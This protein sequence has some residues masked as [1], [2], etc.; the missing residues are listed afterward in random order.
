MIGNRFTNYIPPEYTDG[1]FEQL[2]KIFMQLVTITSGDVAEA[3]NWMNEVDRQYKLTD[4]DYG[5]GDFIEEL[6][7]RGYIKENQEQNVFVLTAKSELSIRRQSLEEIFGKLKKSAK[8][9][10]TTPFSGHGDELTS[11]RREYNFG[12]TL[13]QIDMTDSIKNAQINHGLDDFKLTEKDLEIEEKDF[14]ALTSTVLMIDVSHSMVL[15]G[16]DRITPAKKVAM[17]LAELITTKYPKDTLDIIA[18]GND[19]FPIQ[20]KDL[21]YL[22]VGPYHTN[23]VAGLELAD[24]ILRRRKTNNKQI[25]M[26]TDGKPTCL[27]VGA[28]YY[29]NSFGLDRKIINKTLDQAA[30]CRRQGIAVTTFMIARDPYLQQF[31]REFTKINNGR[32]YYSS[33]TGLGDFLFEDYIRNRRKRVR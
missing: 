4:D 19:A 3:L 31:V 27:K 25:F 32:A 13:D 16:E 23:T 1:T 28:K 2:L 26:I 30:K 33:L 21:P 18:F 11:D 29:K 10:H 6:K 22:E 5:M 8:G 12:D 14:K 20:I 17:A 24:D 7:E 9:N 15:Y